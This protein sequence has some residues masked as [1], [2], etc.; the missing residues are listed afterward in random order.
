LGRSPLEPPKIEADEG[1]KD[2]EMTGKRKKNGD[3]KEKSKKRRKI[4]EM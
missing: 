4:S 1:Q 2:R 3:R